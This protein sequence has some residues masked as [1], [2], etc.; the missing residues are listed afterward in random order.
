MHEE[1]FIPLTTDRNKLK[2]KISTIEIY[3]KLCILDLNVQQLEK[4]KQRWR[5]NVNSRNIFITF[6]CETIKKYIFFLNL[7]HIVFTIEFD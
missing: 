3:K 6:H 2:T 5:N 1:S 4:F 7:K